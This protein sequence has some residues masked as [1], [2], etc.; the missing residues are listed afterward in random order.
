MN[1]QESPETSILSDIGL[2]LKNKR[3]EQGYNLEQ[4]AEITRISL[5]TLK[6]IEEGNLEELPNLVFLR[7]FIRNY[8]RLLSIESDWIVEELNQVYSSLNKNLDIQVTPEVN[9][10]EN[11]ESLE[12]NFTPVFLVA[13]IVI[14]ILGTGLYFFLDSPDGLIAGKSKSLSS[15][16]ENI[17]EQPVSE[18]PDL[19]LETELLEPVKD[20][21]ISLLNL[22]VKVK[23]SGWIRLKIDNQTPFEIAVKKGEKYE[24]PGNKEYELIMTTGALAELYLNGEEI[25]KAA[26]SKNKIY[27]KKLNRFSLTELNN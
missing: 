26:E 16:S 23:A 24:W 9:L 11:N 25:E 15:L 10:F 12:F 13:L 19:N 20:E 1:H 3:E 2:T 4:V 27:K 22:L 5:S 17:D 18:N 21:I 7:G 6:Y 14:S 8:A